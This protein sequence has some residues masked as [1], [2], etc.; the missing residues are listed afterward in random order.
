MKDA[1]ARL[2]GRLTKA[3][4]KLARDAPELPN[5]T[6]T[7]RLYMR[8]LSAVR[9]ETLSAR[10]YAKLQSEARGLSPKNRSLAAERVRG[11][12]ISHR[13]WAA[14]DRD[15]AE[16][17]QRWRELFRDWDVVLCPPTPCPAFK[18]DHSE[19]IESRRLEIDGQ[20]YSYLDSQLV[21]A[22]LATT[23]GLPA[24]V[25]PLDRSASGLPIG[26]QIIGPYL[27]DRTTIAFAALLERE[28]GGFAPPPV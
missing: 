20:P 15:R 4:V 10:D 25:V 24:T 16:L 26:V 3:G 8:L 9:G 6:Q 5:P 11:A 22:E 23:P 2:A 18:H 13:D 12:V 14:A 21:W 19:P 17:R 28:Y 7:A 27:E 1:L